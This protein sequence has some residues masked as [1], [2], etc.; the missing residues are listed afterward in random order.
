MRDA[1]RL[2]QLRE[3]ADRKEKA[4][5]D[6]EA[7]RDRQAGQVTRYADKAAQTAHR[8]GT[9]RDKLAQALREAAAT[10]A[11]AG[12]AQQHRAAVA[13]LDG[14]SLESTGPDAPP[15]AERADGEH[16]A[17]AAY[18]DAPEAP[19]ADILARARRDA[20]A[21]ADRQA[22]AVAQ[23]GRLLDESATC[24]RQLRAAQEAEGRLSAEV[25][26]AADRVTAADLAVE[27]RM[28]LLLDAYRSYLSGLAE[29]RV[30]DPDELIAALESWG[31]TGEGANPAVAIIDAA[32]RG[33]RRGTWPTGRGAQHS[34]DPAC[35]AGGRAGGGDRP[36][37]R[38]R[39]R[40][41][42][43][44]AHAGRRRPRRPSRRAAV[45]GDRLRAGPV[46]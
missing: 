13:A 20:Q 40:R 34:A 32:A 4:A 25:Q 38:G 11:D 10:A 14:T 29:L 24:E 42:A 43:G 28:R 41:P 33:G 39:P 2:E 8:A 15:P 46:R 45:E 1:E 31:L 37:A 26:A 23:L 30:A 17:V 36:A 5:Q 12:C 35:H 7:D 18:L 19:A 6:R 27:E 3:D 22:Q 21:I 44:P 9:G 16:R